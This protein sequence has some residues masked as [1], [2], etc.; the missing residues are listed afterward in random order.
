MEMSVEDKKN[1]TAYFREKI[2]IHRAKLPT[3]KEAIR[4]S[5][6]QHIEKLE[7]TVKELE[8]EATFKTL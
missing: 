3:M 5:M 7:K 6:E 4:I 2:E 8:E 1:L